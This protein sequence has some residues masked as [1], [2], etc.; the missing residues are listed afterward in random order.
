MTTR[1]LNRGKGKSPEPF[2]ERNPDHVYIGR[3]D[4]WGRWEASKWA[5][6]FTIGDDGTRDEVLAK[7]RA[8]LLARPDLL[9]ALPELK[10]KTLFCWCKP[11]ACHGDV[12]AE[13]AE[14]NAGQNG[15]AARE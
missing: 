11:D 7:F 12:L 9:A 10:G 4:P 5:N 15:P 6:P 2:D 8:Y 3:R 1:V 14:G 13:L